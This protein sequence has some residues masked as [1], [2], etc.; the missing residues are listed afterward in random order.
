M[1]SEVHSPVG[2]V[3]CSFPAESLNVNEDTHKLWDGD[4]GMGVVHLNGSLRGEVSKIR[5][6]LLKA[7][8]DV[9]DRGSHEEVLL[10]QTQFLPSGGVVIGIKHGSNSLCALLSEYGVH[11]G[12]IVEAL[13]V[14]LI[15]GLCLPQ[16]QVISTAEGLTLVRDNRR[17]RALG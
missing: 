7:L 13:Q 5:V 10:L 2:D 12:T 17:C 8:D 14:K 4:G 3:P 1:V 15:N 16:A 9:H 11:V 6:G